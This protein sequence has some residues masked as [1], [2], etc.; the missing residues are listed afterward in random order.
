MA[1]I[2]GV[3]YFFIKGLERGIFYSKKRKLDEAGKTQDLK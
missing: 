1:V 2:G 3:N